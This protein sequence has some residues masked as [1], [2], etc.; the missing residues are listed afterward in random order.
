MERT[1]RELA[2]EIWAEMRQVEGLD[3]QV[4]NRITDVIMG[5]LARYD[6]ATIVNDRDLPVKPL[7][8]PPDA[9]Q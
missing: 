8:R 6:G 4:R 3:W 2:G 5:V 7:P 9:E 1:V